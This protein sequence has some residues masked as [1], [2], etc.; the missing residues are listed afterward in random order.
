VYDGKGNR[1]ED[2][3]VYDDQLNVYQTSRVMQF[4][5]MDYSLN[6]PFRA[7]SYNRGHLPLVLNRKG[8]DTYFIF[9]NTN[10]PGKRQRFE[11]GVK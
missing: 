2:G 9:L 10:F 3:L 7:D 11:Y 8:A 6:N 1:V 4:V 5:Q